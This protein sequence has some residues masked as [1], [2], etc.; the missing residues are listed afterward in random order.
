MVYTACHPLLA[1]REFDLFALDNV[2]STVAAALLVPLLNRIL[3]SKRYLGSGLEQGHQP[4]FLPIRH[5]VYL[6]GPNSRW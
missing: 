4:G 2:I 1:V 5:V 6:P 3:C